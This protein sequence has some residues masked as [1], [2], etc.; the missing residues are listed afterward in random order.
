[1]DNLGFGW[2]TL[3]PWAVWREKDGKEKVD[4]TGVL[5]N[6]SKFNGPNELKEVL[7]SQKDLFTR[8][9]TEKMLTYALGRV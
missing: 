4:P 5:P 6:G 3:T 9:L 1:M 2:K 7:K 8:C